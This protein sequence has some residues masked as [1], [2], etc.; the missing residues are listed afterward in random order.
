MIFLCYYTCALLNYI[1]LCSI[2]KKSDGGVHKFA[3]DPTLRLMA[4]FRDHIS[5]MGFTCRACHALLSSR[6]RKRERHKSNM[7]DMAVAMVIS[8]L[9][10]NSDRLDVTSSPRAIVTRALPEQEL[11]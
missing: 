1:L 6:S 2:K 7:L 9:K 10:K 3:S 4:R 8:G 11:S 5:D